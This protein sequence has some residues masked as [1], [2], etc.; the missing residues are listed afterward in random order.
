[1]TLLRCLLSGSKVAYCVSAIERLRSSHPDD[2]IVVFSQFSRMLDVLA[3]SL[4]AS[5]LPFERFGRFDA[6]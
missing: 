4:A 3:V 1:M 2:K 6:L 5:G